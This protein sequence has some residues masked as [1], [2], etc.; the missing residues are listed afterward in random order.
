MIMNLHLLPI[1]IIIC[2][3]CGQ[4]IIQMLKFCSLDGNLIVENTYEELSD[5]TKVT[6]IEQYMD[7]KNM[8][9]YQNHFLMSMLML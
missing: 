1:S 3:S 6:F 2:S 4:V 8:R 5:D 9:I 7:F